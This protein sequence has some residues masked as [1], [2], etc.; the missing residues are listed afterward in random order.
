[1]GDI[2]DVIGAFEANVGMT[3]EQ[4]ENIATFHRKLAELSRRV[5]RD[6]RQQG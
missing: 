6:V 2:E 1:L 5:G 4:M 3:V